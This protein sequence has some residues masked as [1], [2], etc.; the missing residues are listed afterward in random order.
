MSVLIHMK[1]PKDC[2]HCPMINS[3]DECCLLTEEQHD[4][5]EGVMDQVQ[6]AFC[7]LVEI[8]PHGRLIDADAFKDF[9]IDLKRAAIHAYELTGKRAEWDTRITWMKRF[10]LAI[11]DAPTV[12][13]ADKE[14]E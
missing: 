8:L 3:S 10:V 6:A 5:Y 13:Q 12:I 7:P 9:V 1:M 4:M 14:E 11:E 2:W